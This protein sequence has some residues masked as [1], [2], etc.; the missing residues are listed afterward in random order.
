MTNKRGKITCLVEL[1]V[2]VAV[3]LAVVFLAAQLMGI[4]FDPCKGGMVR[5]RLRRT[6]SDMQAIGISMECFK[7]RYGGYPRGS[8]EEVAGALESEGDIIKEVPLVDGWRRSFLLFSYHESDDASLAS[9]YFLVSLGCDGAGGKADSA[10][11]DS[12]A[13]DLV[14]MSG[15]WQTPL[16]QLGVEKEDPV[17]PWEVVPLTAN[18][19]Q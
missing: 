1:L 12:P 8:L 10:T 3:V 4:S 18:T 15:R 2:T 6:V 11:Q 5:G 9:G 16:Q 14:L 17:C 19:T 7:S 13:T